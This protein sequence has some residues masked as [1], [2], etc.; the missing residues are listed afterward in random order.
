MI[1]FLSKSHDFATKIWDFRTK[2]CNYIK[3]TVLCQ[4]LNF[5]K[6]STSLSNFKH[7][8]FKNFQNLQL[9][10]KNLYRIFGQNVK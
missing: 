4:S 8:Q 10:K 3:F 7:Q 9:Y 2:G 5:A 1:T 6:P